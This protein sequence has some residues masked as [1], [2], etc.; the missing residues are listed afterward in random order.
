MKLRVVM[1]LI[2]LPML[3]LSVYYAEQLTEQDIAARD[4]ALGNQITTAEQTY[5]NDLV[6]ELQKER[7][8]SAGFIG[9]GG[10]N[11]QS[12][13]DMQRGETDLRIAPVLT[14][15][16]RAALAHKD[17]YESAKTALA[18]LESKRIEVSQLKLTVPQMAGYYTAMINDLLAFALPTPQD[19][20]IAQLQAL[21]TTRVFLASAKE[22]AGLERAMG[23]TGLGST[24]SA[25]LRDRLLRLQGAQIALLGQAKNTMPDN[26]WQTSLYDTPAFQN[27]E[28][29]RVILSAGITSGDFET[30]TP[31]DW[32]RISTEW[33]EQLRALEKDIALQL[34]DITQSL[35]TASEARLQTTVLTG[36][37]T[38]LVVALL[39]VACFERLIWRI[40]QLTIVVDGFAKGDFSKYVPDIKRNNE[41]SKMATAIYVFKQ[42]TLAMRQEAEELKAA[43]EDMLN[44]KHG[45]VVE[46]VT[47]GLSALAK[48][49]LTRHFDEP[50][51]P[52]YDSI[53]ENFNASTSRLRAVLHSIA[54]AVSELDRS[55]SDMSKSAEDLTARTAEQVSTIRDTT[56]R[57]GKLSSEVESF[58]D[59]INQAS[60]LATNARRSASASANLMQ[61]AMGAMD[62]I[63]TSSEQISQIISMIE[64]ISFQ[65]NLLALNAGVEAARAGSAG[66]GFAV[67][68]SEVRQLALRAS[69]A[70]TEIKTLVDES[71]RSV[72]SG[73]DLVNR[74][75]DA[76][77]EIAQEIARVDDVLERISTGSQAQIAD[78]KSLNTAIGQI[79]QL[80]DRNTEMAQATRSS[81]AQIA[82]RSRDLAAS[83]DDFELG[84][85]PVAQSTRAAA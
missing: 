64:D 55:S 44:A 14:Q 79:N 65:T 54:G 40:K 59:E 78:L 9:S 21:Q 49:D 61:D 84:A 72:S 43:D 51:D 74:T 69:A 12:N 34:A 22:S 7:G 81:S 35:E 48:A 68:A 25:P 1:L 27:V 41:I 20:D 53:R 2:L 26:N 42:E 29:A 57:V 58:G 16:S 50:L 4:N 8:Y 38:I 30:L 10:T 5:I 17:A 11:F 23:A 60:D 62:K 6:H 13:L 63:S 37:I 28:A 33:I 56:A 36:I 82:K 15:T 85:P 76:L 18:Q 24:F 70:T 39:A 73:V 71:G 45:K 46:L 31:Q 77:T 3:A 67:V 80:A 19:A 32:F 66:R 52:D 75:G 47:E 83:V